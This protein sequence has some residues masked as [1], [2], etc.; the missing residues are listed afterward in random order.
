MT[1]RRLFRSIK[2]TLGR[3]LA[4]LAIIALGVGFFTGLKS[5]QPAMQRT[6]G[7]YLSELNMYD[8]QVMSTLGF[9]EDDETA[10]EESGIYTAVEA[11]YSLETVS[12]SSSGEDIAY[13]ALSLPDKLALPLV[14]SGRLPQRNDEC[15]VDEAAFDESDIGKEL[16]LSSVDDDSGSLKYDSFT[17]VG[18]ARSPRYISTE[19]GSTSIGSGSISG[20][21]YLL[22][23]A[24]DCEVYH[25]ILLSTGVSG[26]FCSD[27][28]D[29]AVRS[30]KP[31]TQSLLN[32][33]ANARY[34]ELYSEAYAD[35]KDAES[36]LTDGWRQYYEARLGGVPAEMLDDTAKELN[37]AGREIKD[38]KKEL[39][40]IKKPTTYL[41]T[42]KENAGYA[43]F[44]NDVVIISGIAN[45]F[46]VFFVLIAALVCL[47]TMT[48]MV[49]EERTQIGTLKAMGSS[50]LAISMKYVLYVGLASFIGCIVGFFLGTGV[51]PRIIWS[52]YSISYGFTELSYYFSPLMYLASLA[53]SV[54]GSVLI[55]ILACSNELKGKPAELIRPKP[56]ASGRRILLER[57]KPLWKRLSFLS[58]VTLRNALRYKKRVIMML[59]GISGCTALLITGFGIS[60]SV[61]DLLDYQYDEILLYDAAATFD[62][63]ADIVELDE[64][65]SAHS[66]SYVLS[67]SE[68]L[69]VF[70]NEGEKDADVV[71]L[72][73]Q[74]AEGYFDL[75]K[76]SEKIS[77]PQKGHCVISKKLAGMLGVKPS[78]TVAVDINGRNVEL[79]IDGICDN[80]L[81]HYLY[82]SSDSLPDY[83]PNTAY[84]LIEEGR[85]AEEGAKLRS[86]KDISY[87]SVTSEERATAQ[88]SMSSMNYI[89]LLVIL[90]A[91]ALAFIVLYNLTNINIME[92]V[93]EVATVKVLG[94]HS[95]ETASYVLRENL[96]LSVLGAVIGLP[97][98][99]L[100]HAYIMMQIK[101]DSMTFDVRIAAASY[102]IAFA[103]TVLFALIANFFMRFKL[104]KVKMA[105]S[106][107][108]VE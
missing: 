79:E 14:T 18:L 60:D 44:E 103:L 76:G 77:Y 32:E 42:L 22:K 66:N 20:F 50:A 36:E 28:Y 43:E 87:V 70:S 86:E 91:G 101:V 85:S 29:E 51:I 56:P 35:L 52:V 34:D 31:E 23:E 2:K 96:M 90:C 100:L 38:G 12:S 93:R 6:G 7:A 64:A 57:V 99:K 21:V 62:E 97:L 10:F 106:L 48:R 67:Y 68:E 25:E 95:R 84:L 53:V 27:E 16:R 39:D 89:I 71:A 61:A 102:A 26:A 73:P 5:A 69:T 8:F 37:D 45:A 55:T 47:T 104:E 59:I 83:A 41:L 40:K 78:N 49:N 46:P 72:A 108:E 30:E 33:R 88:R 98:G 65:L 4:I 24:F 9:T 58:K 80:Y 75:H 107:K 13:Q 3:F 92:R 1:F 105:E 82:I 94:F 15:L 17:I 19:R 81:G 74:D 11:G 54:L 63:G